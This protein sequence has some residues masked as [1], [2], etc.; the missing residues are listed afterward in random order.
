MRARDI[1]IAWATMLALALFGLVMAGPANAQHWRGGMRGGFHGPMMRGPAFHGQGLGGWHGGGYPYIHQRP[2][3]P[4]RGGWGP[5]A[6]VGGL[7]AGL[8]AGV[9]VGIGEAIV[10]AGEYDQTYYG[11]PCWRW[12]G[13]VGWVRV[14]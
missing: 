2:W 3:Y 9:G 4:M 7:A 11:N 1:W 5:G 13:L 6:V 10:G 8:A 14:C 12:D